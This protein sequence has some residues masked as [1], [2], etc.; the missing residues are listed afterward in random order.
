MLTVPHIF[1]P[2]SSRSRAQRAYVKFAWK[3]RR[4]IHEIM[5]IDEINSLSR[6]QFVANLGWV[7]EHSPWVA[8]RAWEM[9]PFSDVHQL[10]AAMKQTVKSASREEQLMLLLAHPDLGTHARISTASSGEQ[11]GA[12]LDNLNSEEYQRLKR[13]NTE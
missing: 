13:L 10:H 6:D 3:A 5:T 4:S 7:F 2:L 11:S 9:R 1:W 12:G 8:E